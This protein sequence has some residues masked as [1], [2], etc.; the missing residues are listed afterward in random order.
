MST[1]NDE[2]FARGVHLDRDGDVYFC[3]GGKMLTCKRTLVNDGTTL[4]DRA[5]KYGCDVCDLKFALLPEGAAQ[6]AAIDP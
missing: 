3:P 2:T 4:L 6:S 5:G 1:R